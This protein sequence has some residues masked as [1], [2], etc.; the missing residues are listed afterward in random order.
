MTIRK[1]F[2]P[3]IFANLPYH[4]LSA[5]SEKSTIGEILNFLINFD[6]E[7][8]SVTDVLTAPFTCNDRP[9]I[10]YDSLVEKLTKALPPSTPKEAVKVMAWGRLC[11]ALPPPIQPALIML[12][13][14]KPPGQKV[15]SRLDDAVVHSKANNSIAAVAPANNWKESHEVKVS[16]KFSELSEKLDSLCGCL[17]TFETKLTNL[18]NTSKPFQNEIRC[19]KCGLLGH[20]SRN[21]I[22][23]QQGQSW[24]VVEY[25]HTP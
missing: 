20:I 18:Q 7:H 25:I 24:S 9:S 17:K 12:E 5:V 6:T 21:C 2:A 1:K 19:F 13:K 23:S 8:E 22:N 4:L 3:L 15:L 11:E 16:S 10:F 14:D